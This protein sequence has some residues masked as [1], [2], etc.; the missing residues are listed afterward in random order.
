MFHQRNNSSHLEKT[1]AY[2]FRMICCD[3]VPKNQ[4]NMEHEFH[5]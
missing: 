4:N 1:N 5:L 2:G 3:I